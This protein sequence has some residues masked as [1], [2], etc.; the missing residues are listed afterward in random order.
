MNIW[1]SSNVPWNPRRLFNQHYFV[2]VGKCHLPTPPLLHHPQQIQP[3]LCGMPASDAAL[4][5]SPRELSYS[6]LC[7]RGARL[8]SYLR[9]TRRSVCGS[10]YRR[11]LSDRN[12]AEAAEEESRDREPIIRTSEGRLSWRIDCLRS[13]LEINN[14]S[15]AVSGIS[16]HFE[17]TDSQEIFL[18]VGYIF[19][20][21]WIKNNE[22]VC[23]T[24]WQFRYT[25]SVEILRKTYRLL[26]ALS[27]PP[28]NITSITS[29]TIIGYELVIQSWIT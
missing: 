20:L 9:S 19:I 8:S 27:P 15:F 29:K 24:F 25:S 18:K 6:P 7:R 3:H 12:I 17:V 11:T 1:D 28:P 2:P 22:V 21:S 13:D 5:P 26:R 4:T 16:V 10:L 14:V 23:V